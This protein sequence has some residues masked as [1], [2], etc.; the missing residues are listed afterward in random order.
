MELK[1][2]SPQESDTELQTL[3]QGLE[4]TWTFEDGKL[5]K[6]FKFKNFIEAFG[7]MTRAAMV[8]EKK[9]HHPEWFNVYNTVK[10][11]LTTH[12]VD[13]LSFKDFDLAKRMETLATGQ[14]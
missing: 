10:I 9:G 3:N 1:R 2:Y 11:Q 6:T 4:K 13:G 5:T 14:R 12:D 7:F 8:A